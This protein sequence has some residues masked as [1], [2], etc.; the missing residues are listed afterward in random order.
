MGRRKK[1]PPIRVGAKITFVPAGDDPP[2]KTD[3]TDYDARITALYK[4][5]DP[6]DETTNDQASFAR[7]EITAD[8]RLPDGRAL[9]GVKGTWGRGKGDYWS[10]P[11]ISS[12]VL[13][14][15]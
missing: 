7:A 14:Y 10:R 5:G 15:S 3:N 12:M 9:K 13:N 11:W 8:I 1:A 2:F 4:Q 6:V